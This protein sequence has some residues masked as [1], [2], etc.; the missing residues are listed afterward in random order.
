MPFSSACETTIKIIHDDGSTWPWT[1]DHVPMLDNPTMKALVEAAHRRGKLAVVHVLSEPQARDAIASGADGLAHL[2]IGDSVSADFSEFAANHHVFVIPTFTTLY[3]ICGKSPG[4]AIL[5]RYA[6]RPYISKEWQG[7][8][9]M[10]KPD[11]P[12]SHRCIA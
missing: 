11:P 12:A 8:M 9:N 5:R 3:F 6:S 4:P 2:F 1:K 7:S 10:P